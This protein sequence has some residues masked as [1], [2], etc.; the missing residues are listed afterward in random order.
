MLFGLAGK[1]YLNVAHK[2]LQVAVFRKKRT[3]A[4][5]VNM[6]CAKNKS[7]SLSRCT[8]TACKRIKL[9]SLQPSL[10]SSPEET[11]MEL[12]SEQIHLLNFLL[13]KY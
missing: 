8:D 1:A 2:F 13:M 6:V 9:V 3:E 5:D 10:T 12:F 11:L 7:L 4:A